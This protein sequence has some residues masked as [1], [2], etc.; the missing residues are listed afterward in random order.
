[1]KANEI[2]TASERELLINAMTNLLDEY[3]YNYKPFALNKIIDTWA[4]SKQD[5]ITAFKNHPNYVEG[6]FII[7]Y[8]SDFNRVMDEKPICRF[9]DWL[10]NCIWS[11]RDFL[12]EDLIEQATKECCV[13]PGQMYKFFRHL[14]NY[15]TQFISEELAMEI[16]EIFPFAHAH[17]G[18][19]M[20]RVMNKIL[21]YM[22][23]TKL[24]DYNREYAKFAD[25]LSPLVIKR[26]TVLSLNP[27][28]YLTM[29]FG[30]SWASC[31]TI[32]KENRRHMPNSY[33]GMYSSG[34]MS[35]MLDS[36]SMVFYTVD[37]SYNGDEYWTQPKMNR[38]MF[39]WGK[40]KL[41]QGR[42]YPQDNDGNVMGYTDFRG[43]VQNI[44]SVIYDFP[45]LWTVSKGT[46]EASR[47][48]MSRGTH[49]KD[50]ENFS[51]CTL[52]R[53]KGNENNEAFYVG[54]SPI[55]IECGYEHHVEDN[56]NCCSS[57]GHRCADCGYSIVDEDDVYWV[58]GVAY[59]EDC[60]SY[61]DCCEEYFRE[62]LTE[63]GYGRY[64]CDDCLRE[65]YRECADC[66]SWRYIGDGYYIDSIDDYVCEDCFDNYRYC[67]ECEEYHHYSNTTYIEGENEYVCDNCL[68]EHFQACSECGEFIRNADVF[69]DE[70][71]NAYCSS[72]YAD[73]ADEEDEDMDE[74]M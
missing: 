3:D 5:L 59:C 18:Q 41:V 32:D 36:S 8:T 9:S 61:C 14:P 30:N 2:I 72:C 20:S 74:A 25:A 4:E 7:A 10:T 48:I 22:G 15:A 28:D 67:E 31:H 50:Y 21:T 11:A 42:L 34:T 66:G 37:T 12:P 19:K 71:G 47:Y 70:D 26:H 54:H 40:E 43:I 55:C 38:Q 44:M 16:N 62:D 29:S 51:N 33:S 35:Y 65:H 1:M 13:I 53:I 46:Y 45:N 27:L 39:H 56:I 68:D 69:K 57:S 17:K 73:L 64:V 58:D 24:P 49:Y 63:V 6:K 52:S 60:V 23:Y